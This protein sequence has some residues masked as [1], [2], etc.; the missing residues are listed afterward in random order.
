[1]LRRSAPAVTLYYLQC[2]N[3]SYLGR[4]GMYVPGISYDR[5][6]C[7]SFG[8]GYNLVP[9]QSVLPIDQDLMSFK[10]TYRS[11]LRLR[12]GRSQSFHGAA[13][14]QRYSKAWA[15]NW[16]LGEAGTTRGC[17]LKGT[18]DWKIKLVRIRG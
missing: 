6:Y 2:N 9:P 8:L 15:T 1:V 18:I 12:V 16:C 10:D 13:N 7:C 5:S 14:I 17:T 11:L 4:V 3:G